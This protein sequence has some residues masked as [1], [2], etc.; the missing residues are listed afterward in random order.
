M[1]IIYILILLASLAA[2]FKVFSGELIIE[3]DSDLNS[4]TFEI[5]KSG[6]FSIWI[7]GEMFSAAALDIR[8]AKISDHDDND[9]KPIKSFF[10]AQVNGFKKG[11]TLLKYYYLKKGMYSF[12]VVKE[13]EDSLGTISRLLMKNSLANRST[14]FSYEL[15]QT[16]PEFILPILILGIVLPIFKVL[17]YLQVMNY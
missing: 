8:N 13:Q 4:M 9:I 6:F 11:R 5:S 7:K 3:K 10:R 15:R 2:L 16:F 14:I 1:L 17:E 12:R